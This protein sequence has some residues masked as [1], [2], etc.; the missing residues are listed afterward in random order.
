V[1][2]V[3]VLA[4]GIVLA[5]LATAAVLRSQLPSVDRP[6]ATPS[7][8]A[9]RPDALN[10]AAGRPNAALLADGRVLLMTD[11]MR[12]M[13]QVPYAEL[14]NPVTGELEATGQPLEDRSRST[15]TRLTDGRV[16]VVGGVAGR[17]DVNPGD[18]LASAEIW[19]A[20]TVGFSATGA[21]AEARQGHSATPLPDGRV[22]VIGGNR[23]GGLF[24]H[25]RSGN[26]ASAEVWDPPTGAWT[27]AGNLAHARSLH[28]ATLLPDGTVLVAGGVG[29]R[30]GVA[31]AEIWDPAT[32]GFAAAGSLA[33]PR[34]SHSA[35]ALSDGRI[36]IAGGEGF[37]ALSNPT[38]AG[39]AA[40]EIWALATGA[41]SPAGRLSTGWSGH[42]A[43]R[44]LDGRVA[45]HSGSD[46][47]SRVELWDP[48]TATFSPGAPLPA[49]FRALVAGF[50]PDGT[51]VLVG[52][53]AA[54]AHVVDGQWVG[55]VVVP[56]FEYVPG[57]PPTPTTT[58][59]DP[60]ANT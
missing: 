16:L 40:A 43:T 15:A 23:I 7:S 51:L 55:R 13:Q 19:D 17:S 38:A 46:L 10:Q 4:A 59:A 37:D 60:G 53:P 49:S 1:Y 30:G 26:L 29:D 6:A 42:L 28:S 35:T 57:S 39:L 31:E 56:T 48:S 27:R 44:L 8:P 9:L 41:F 52:E 33:T 36:L 47:S 32:G 25:S 12:K 58:P 50:R 20:G 34:T 11:G 22:L 54:G 2:T 45:I 3:T 5:V 24:T 18:A 21:L 14:L